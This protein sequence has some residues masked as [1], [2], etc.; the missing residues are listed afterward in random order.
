MKKY[1]FLFVAS[2]LHLSAFAQATLQP[3]F[4]ANT[5][6][7]CEPL[8][9]SFTDLS[10]GNPTSWAWDFGNGNTSALQ[11]PSATYVNAGVYTVKL[12]INNATATDSIIKT[13][14]ITVYAKPVANFLISKTHGK[15]F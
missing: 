13:N 15:V 11:N 7:G 10:T 9:V 2:V 1:L 3:D 8:T 12:V 14:Y 6:S 4:S 5:L